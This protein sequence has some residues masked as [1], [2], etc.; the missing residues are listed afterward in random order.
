MRVPA[1]NVGFLTSLGVNV[2]D[3]FIREGIRAV[4]DRVGAPYRAYY[5][6]KLDEATLAAPREDEPCAL[7]DKYWDSDVFVQAGAPVYWHLLGG[8]STSLTSEWHRWMWEE[9]ILDVSREGPAFVNLGA[10]SC[11]P[12]NDDGAAFLADA[13]CVAFARRASERAALTT[14]R[15]PLAASIFGRLA[16]PHE[17]LPCPAFLAAARHRPASGSAQVIGVNLMPLGGHFVLDAAFDAPTWLL[18]CIALVARLRSVG[19]LLFIAHDAEEASFMASFAGP[20]ER[21]FRADGWRDYLDAYA[22]CSVV[23]ANRVHGA[24]CA[25]GFG[26]PAVIVGNDSRAAIG[27]PIGLSRFRS[28]DEVDS[29]CATAERLL[30]SRDSE[31]DRLRALR[32]ATLA[33]YAELL[34]PIVGAAATGRRRGATRSACVAPRVALASVAELEAPAF[35]AFVD[36]LNRF[37]ARYGMRQFVS[38]S[39]IWE[40]PWLWRNALG[41]LPWDRLRVV[42]LGSE[43]SPMPWLMASLGAKVVLVETDAQFVPRWEAWQRRLGTDVEWHVVDSEALPVADEW[44]DLVTSFSVIEHQPDKAAA[45]AEA[46][47]VLAPGGLL[48]LSFDICEPS[49][50][51]TFPA[52]NGAALTMQEFTQLVWSHP[53]FATPAAPGWNVEDIPAFRAW[54]SATAP[55]HDYVVAAAVLQ[56]LPSGGAGLPWDARTHRA[57]R[58]SPAGIEDFSVSRAKDLAVVRDALEAYRVVHRAYPRSSGGWDGLRSKWGEAKDEWISGLVPDHLERLPRDPR[59]NDRPDEQYLYKSDGADYKLISHGPDDLAAVATAHPE[60]IDPVRPGWAYGY[61]SA[62]ARDW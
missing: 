55:H 8:R 39:K 28:G 47:R 7:R 57:V 20:G 9:R 43:L 34:A 27:D 15:D 62:G 53:V 48:A 40:Y 56:K 21:V 60:L 61:W 37:G 22:A 35:R 1:I 38:W 11:Q 2:G 17:L 23:V 50:G 42:D 33:R 6:H 51:M 18:R 36:A 54:H 5:V 19:Q 49:L 3:E 44:A 12:W 31:A 14:V 16:L 59:E 41:G 10:G 52:W 4:L 46:I 29:V 45:V 30:A 26:V 24:V 13:D 32:D 25:A 58:T